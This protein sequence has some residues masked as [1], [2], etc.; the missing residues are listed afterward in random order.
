MEL[1]RPLDAALRERLK[2][3]SVH[4]T[5][6]AQA[7]G[8][9]PSWLNKYMNGS[10]KATVDDVVRMVALLIGVNLQ[11]L[12]GVESRVLK[13]LRMVPEERRE[14]AALVMVTAAKG[15]RRGPR[16]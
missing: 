2:L 4:Q 7:I 15:Y 8:R 6:L 3:T 12:S 11:P 9:S 14:D 1:P 10:G 5:H 13:A 16:P